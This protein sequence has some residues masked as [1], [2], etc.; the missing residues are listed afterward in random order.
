[1]V[2]LMEFVLRGK[3]VSVQARLEPGACGAGSR[4]LYFLHQSETERLRKI[5]SLSREQVES[6]LQN[7][8]PEPGRRHFVTVHGRRYP[9]KQALASALGLSRLDFT[10][11]EARDKLTRLGFPVSESEAW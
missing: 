1:V 3:I 10:T 11:Q 8:T 2:V 4:H 7:K 9:V 6:A 5:Y